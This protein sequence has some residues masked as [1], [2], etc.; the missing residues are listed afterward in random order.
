MLDILKLF[1]SLY[2]LSFAVCKSQPA[3]CLEKLLSIIDCVVPACAPAQQSSDMVPALH[4]V[5]QADTSVFDSTKHG[6]YNIHSHTSQQ[7]YFYNSVHPY[8]TNLNH[9]C[10][11]SAV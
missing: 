4:R 11:V 1:T 2:R 10:N 3:T 6:I 9:V 7:I 5:E 8:Q